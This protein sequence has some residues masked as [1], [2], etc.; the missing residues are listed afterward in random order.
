MP[1]PNEQWDA[2]AD[3]MRAILNATEERIAGLFRNRRV[4]AASLAEGDRLHA[5]ENEVRTRMDA[6]IAENINL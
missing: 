3:E 5:A 1:T 6:F 4:S 2:L